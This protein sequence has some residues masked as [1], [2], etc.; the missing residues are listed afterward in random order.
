[1]MRKLLIAAA[2]CACFALSA[3]AQTPSAEPT[4]MGAHGGHEHSKPSEQTAN[5]HLAPGEVLHRGAP[6]GDSPAVKFADVLKEPSK[7]AGK[8]VIVEGVVQSSCQVRG[9][10]LEFAPEKGV[11]GIRAN[12]KDEAFFVPFNSAGLRARAEGTFVVTALSKED[13]EQRAKQGAN[14][15]RNPDGTANEISFTATGVELRK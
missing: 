13:A 11:R 5:V 10:W 12:M 8:Q 15:Q 7:Y 6:I 4:D 2:L 14:L 1:M 3:A 9:C